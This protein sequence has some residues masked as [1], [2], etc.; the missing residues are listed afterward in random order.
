[1]SVNRDNYWD[2]VKSLGI[3][4]V[5]LGHSCGCKP[6]IAY[7]YL[8]SLPVFFFVSGYM[9]NDK[10][11][12]DRLQIYIGHRI[13]ELMPRLMFYAAIL[14]LMHNPLVSAGALNSAPY[15]HSQMLWNFMNY[16]VFSFPD[17]MS[18]AIWFIPVWLIAV[19]AFASIV[20]FV[21]L[22]TKRE[23]TGIAVVSVLC[24]AVTVVGMFLMLRDMKLTMRLEVACAV[25]IFLLFGFLLRKYCPDF[26]KY[27]K[28][29][30][31]L[32]SGAA[33]FYISNRLGVMM[34]LS[35]N[36][37]CPEW[38]VIHSLLGIILCLVIAEYLNRI[39]YVD[40]VFA[41]IGKHSFDIMALHFVVFKLIDI[42]YVKLHPETIDNLIAF[43]T[44]FSS[45]LRWLYLIL[46]LLI[47][48]LVGSLFDSI[49]NKFVT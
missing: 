12:G 22:F 13:V 46:G 42:A 47:P 4:C 7:V 2:I 3:I 24:V 26:R 16:A 33:L 1:M 35:N 36:Y 14:V 44:G 20:S 27:A 18:G 17:N 32:I 15:N 48:V 39:K 49:K 28:W 25:V 21:R 40:K 8:F 5:V 41:I 19:I 31:G 6:V 34:D 38:Y 45:E 29:Y 9:Y 23:R 43:P 10:K 11:Y 30:V 37:I